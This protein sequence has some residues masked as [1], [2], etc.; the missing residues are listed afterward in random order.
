[1]NEFVGMSD[2][3]MLLRGYD[4]K[5]FSFGRKT[6]GKNISFN[7]IISKHDCNKKRGSDTHIDPPSDWQPK[8]NAGY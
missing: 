2:F 4:S 1:M 5:L 7:S 8:N 3:E 6:L